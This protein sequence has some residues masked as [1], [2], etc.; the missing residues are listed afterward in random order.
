MRS[1][2]CGHSFHSSLDISVGRTFGFFRKFLQQLGLDGIL[3]LPPVENEQELIPNPADIL[4]KLVSAFCP[5][6][7]KIASSALGVDT[8]L[9]LPELW[10]EFLVRTVDSF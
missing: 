10:V 2:N 8:D 4:C 3:D 6:R 5:S 7:V 1:S 9:R